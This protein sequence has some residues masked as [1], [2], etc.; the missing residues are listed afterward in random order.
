MSGQESLPDFYPSPEWIELHAVGLLISPSGQCVAPDAAICTAL[1]TSLYSCV[2]KEIGI[3][4][5]LQVWIPP[6]SILFSSLVPI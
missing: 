3:L 6:W 2:D 1:K 4:R 5:Q